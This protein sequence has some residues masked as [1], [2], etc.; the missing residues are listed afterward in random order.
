MSAVLTFP[1]PSA[2][3]FISRLEQ[4]M[5]RDIH[6]S[7]EEWSH[8]VTALTQ[9]ERQNLL[10]SPTEDLLKEHKSLTDNL[11]HLGKLLRAVSSQE[12]FPDKTLAGM[13]EAGVH[14]LEDKLLLWH[15]PMGQEEGDH[16][17]REVGLL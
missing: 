12:E 10:D 3:D 17:L 2:T 6:D 13:V 9:W 8:C 14:I 4:R 7:A 5:L 11:L 16:V 1:L 15:A